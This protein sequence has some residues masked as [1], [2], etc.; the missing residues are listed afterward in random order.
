MKNKHGTTFR[1]ALCL[2]MGLVLFFPATAMAA[3]L[4]YIRIGE[5]KDFTRIVF[6][7]RGTVSFKKP[8]VKGKG[9][10]AVVFLNTKTTLPKKIVSETA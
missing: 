4:K 2:W 6:E 10:V 7:F 8:E 1:K 3:D 9:N 5:H